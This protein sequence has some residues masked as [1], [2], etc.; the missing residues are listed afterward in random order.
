MG[1][2]IPSSRTASASSRLLTPSQSA[3]L[4]V[5]GRDDLDAVAIGVGLHNGHHGGAWCHDGAEGLKV[6]SNSGYIDF[7]P[8]QHRNILFYGRS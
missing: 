8:A 7:N 6:S 4:A 2:S 5:N 3:Y 1:L